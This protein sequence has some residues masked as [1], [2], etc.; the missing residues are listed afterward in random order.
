[1]VSAADPRA[2]DAGAQMLRA[3]GNAVDAAI[4]TLV[5]LNL[6]EP[7]SSGIGGGGYMVYSE[8]G[9]APVTYD[10]REI[11]PAAATPDWWLV[12]GQLMPFDDAQ[13]GGKSVGVP[14]NL[15]MLALAHREH[16]KLPWAS[17]FQ[18]A[19]KL[20]RDGFKVTP[21]LHNSL[22][23]Y[24]A[25]G[26]LSAEARKIFYNADGSENYAYSQRVEFKVRTDAESKLAKI[27]ELSN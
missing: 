6:V 3:G 15:R 11:A 4:A 8:R 24:R 20:A 7:Q 12:N 18:P 22:D 10:G 1:M 17:L 2:A 25:T 5:T 26:A 9:A 23:H 16:G 21:R 19:I 27:L 13:P 14:G